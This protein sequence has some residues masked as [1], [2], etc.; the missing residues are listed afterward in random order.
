MSK[1][2][3][4][5]FA[6]FF[7]SRAFGAEPRWI[8]MP[9]DDFEIYSSAGEGD[10][11]QALQYFERVRGF[12]EQALGGSEQKPDP[13]RIII[14]N[15]KKEYEPYRP[16][17][18]AAA[19][20]TQVA[21][22]DYIVLGGASADVF[23]VAVHEYVHLVASHGG[24]KLPPWL[25]E[26]IAEI[27]ST[28]KPIGDKVMVGS[29]IPGRMYALSR[30]KWVPLAVIIAADHNSPYYNE[31][32]KA[33]SLYNEGWA[34]THMLELSPEY[35]PGFTKVL[36][37]IRKGTPSQP[38]L[39]KVYGKPLASIEKD[40]QGY[41]AGDRFRASLFPIKL[42]EEKVR[43]AAEPASLFDVKLTLLD[44]SN[45]PGREADTRKKLEE[46]VADNPKRPEPY[47]GLGYLAARGK[48]MEDAQKSFKQAV[49]L[50]SKNPQMLWDYGRMAGQ[51]DSPQSIR[52]L[53]ALLEQQPA[54]LEVR[55]FLAQVQLYAKQPQS[56]IETLRP[57]RNVS[58]AD[59]SRFFQ[60]LAFAY[61]DAGNKEEAATAARRWR[62]NTK[63][64]DRDTADSFVQY[65]ERPQQAARSAP[66]DATRSAPPRELP[67]PPPSPGDFAP[68]AQQP[69]ILPS[70]SG[71][72]VEMDCKGRQP[73]L[74]L[75]TEDG[76]V[77]FL[78]DD[79]DKLTAYGL[80][81]A[82]GLELTCGPQ[83]G[84]KVRIQYETPSNAQAGVMGLARGIHFEPVPTLKLR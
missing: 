49:D 34:L 77:V 53:S 29:I 12:F 55:L 9:S 7:I 18:F 36:E 72:F 81:N 52:A 39:E 24:L 60:L 73:K 59:A 62:E 15:S 84:V 82:T 51:T 43:T 71:V 16:N 4:L 10:T 21:G 11:R 38:A 68:E 76:R 37:E 65:L 78:M 1:L 32:S 66:Q 8:K 13:V 67:T 63:D 74:I 30:E 79:A 47:V 19:Y 31:T 58:M 26:G 28:L 56:T 64:A 45:R 54:R 33:G 80:P 23:P 46:L 40:L 25:N 27:Y 6:I 35:H 44:L 61:N 14:F 50:G 57:V 42:R 75:Q 41:L 22:R 70:V 3:R 2:A 5:A 48:Q 83:K 17:E 69:K 20:Y